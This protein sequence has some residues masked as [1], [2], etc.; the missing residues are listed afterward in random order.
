MEY[1]QFFMFRAPADGVLTAPKIKLN[2][3]WWAVS[4][5]AATTAWLE[6]GDILGSA[7]EAAFFFLCKAA[8][9]RE[10]L[11]Q[12]CVAAPCSPAGPCGWPADS[13]DDRDLCA[14]RGFG[15]DGCRWTGV[16]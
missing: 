14:A 6:I 13:F 4:Q 2:L 3:V 11:L 16:A 15:G 12:P 9:P 10:S 7:N 1:L 5:G 8:R